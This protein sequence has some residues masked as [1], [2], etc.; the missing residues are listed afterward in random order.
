MDAELVHILAEELHSSGLDAVGAGPEVD[1]VHVELEDALL[2]EATLE[3]GRHKCLVDLATHRELTADE[4]VLDDLLGDRR[5]TS[6]AVVDQVVKSGGGDSREVNPLMLEVVGVLGGEDGVD[7]NLGHRFEGDRLR[8]ATVVQ[9]VEH[10][11]RV[12]VDA[13]HTTQ[14][15]E[16]EFHCTGVRNP[17]VL[18]L[19]ECAIG[20][21]CPQEREKT[22]PPREEQG[23]RDEGGQ[24]AKPATSPFPRLDLVNQGF[25]GH[26]GVFDVMGSRRVPD[27]RSPGL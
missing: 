3:L 8:V 15:G 14:V 21:I 1:R 5:S 27:L 25:S 2:G 11:A 26:L 6:G 10:L 22:D 23:H 12:G 19:L 4:R 9:L 17:F 16:R 18:K 20:R 7:N 24:G 13:A